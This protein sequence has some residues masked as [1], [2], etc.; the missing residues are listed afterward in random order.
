ME[1]PTKT[2]AT[3]ARKLTRCE[4]E[5]AKFVDLR[6]KYCRK[7]PA[8][9]EG[10]EG[11]LFWAMAR[12][13]LGVADSAGVKHVDSLYFEDRLGSACFLYDFGG[14]IMYARV[15]HAV[16]ALLV[17]ASVGGALR[18]ETCGMGIAPPPFMLEQV[19]LEWMS[20]Y[21]ARALSSAGDRL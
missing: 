3:P 2:S 7:Q 17:S 12:D 13:Y 11:R 1:T 9:V 18:V 15:T 20:E 4:R 14:Q 10:E 21:G 19:P 5:N 8:V 16:A 6:I